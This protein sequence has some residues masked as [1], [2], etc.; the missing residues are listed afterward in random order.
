M[1]FVLVNFI[2]LKHLKIIKE[3]IF[4]I[5]LNPSNVSISFFGN[6]SCKGKMCSLDIDEI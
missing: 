3:N 6:Q 5:I 1:Y 2:I 4:I